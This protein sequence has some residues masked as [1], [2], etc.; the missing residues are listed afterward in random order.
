MGRR[1]AS[2]LV[3]AG[4]VLVVGE[5]T[6]DAF[7]G[8][9]IAYLRT[10]AD[11][12]ATFAG[13]VRF[14][15]PPSADQLAG[16]AA[17]G[18]RFTPHHS[19]TVYPAQI[20]LAAVDSLAARRGVAAVECAWRPGAPPPLHEAAPAVEADLAQAVAAPGGGTLSGRGVTIAALDSGVNLDHMA[21]FARSGEVLNWIDGDASGDL[22]PGDAVD[23]DADGI[24]EVDETLAWTETLGAWWGGNGFGRFDAG[25][26]VLFHDADHDG[27]RD[28]GLPDHDDDAPTLGEQLFLADD[29]DGD[30]RLGVDEHLLALG[31][32][33]L[34][35][36]RDADGRVYR[37]GVDLLAAPG[38]QWP[39]GTAVTGIAIGGWSGLHGM[40]G[41]APG[42]EWLEAIIR[43]A[44][45]PPFA[46]GLADHLAWAVAEGADVVLIEDGEWVW[47]HLDGS[48]NL[49]I[50][51]NELAAAG[52]VIVVPAGNLA[53]GGLH[54]R[55]RSG[56]GQTLSVVG[57]TTTSWPTFLWTE[58]VALALEIHPPVGEAFM[59]PLDGSVVVAYG[60]AIYSNLTISPRGTRRIDLELATAWS[61]GVIPGA[62]SFRFLGPDCDVHGYLFDD[63]SGWASES[64]WS[65][66]R[67]P[68]TTVTWPAT[69]DSAIT[70]AAFDVRA[71]HADILSYSGRGPRLDGAPLV[72]LAAP[73][74][75][76]TADPARWNG[77]ASFAGTSCAGPFVAGAA[78]LLK[79]LDPTLDHGRC[80]RYLRAGAIDRGADPHAAGAGNLSVMAAVSRLLDDLAD[81]P[82]P[83]RV[84]VSNHPNPFNTGTTIRFRQPARGAAHVRVFDLAGREIWACEV[85]SGP[86][87]WRTV[88]WE[89]RDVRG[90]PVASGV[91]LAHVRAAGETAACKLSLVR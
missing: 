6:A 58:P 2:W 81:M 3:L 39:H 44:D 13:T 52:V 17:L 24:G 35:A 83:R 62:W 16:L 28:G 27:H 7:V 12:I 41:V 29:R 82:P 53:A 11:K 5:A 38:D 9:R 15:A 8:G 40:T 14:T 79:E 55:F 42:A 30:G 32:S 50:M 19:R 91:Y 22:S 88:A 73:D 63:A 49:E 4:L 51:L 20:P 69:A 87:G 54:C 59:L 84:Q 67:N 61:G 45:M 72:D 18:V 74:F 66:G 86:A 60:Y 76:L 57:E 23:L 75:A 48:S 46:P 85:V 37:R 90:V 89:G 65:H 34:R 26:D 64:S 1:I 77:Y 70:V 31:P 71:D 78:A 47:E 43:Y 25:W 33:K 80:R 56:D 36:V 68:A 21:L 10:R